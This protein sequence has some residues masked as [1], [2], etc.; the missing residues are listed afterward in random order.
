MEN[1]I[2]IE[3]FVCIEIQ[4]VA[5]ILRRIRNRMNDADM[6]MDNFE[7]YTHETLGKRIK[8]ELTNDQ[9]IKKGLECIGNL[10]RG[11]RCQ[12]WY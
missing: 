2:H 6:K 9:D 11:L 1:G 10:K 4:Q 5:D 8:R 12:T 7:V 3:N